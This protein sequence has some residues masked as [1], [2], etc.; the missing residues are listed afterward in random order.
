MKLQELTCTRFGHPASP[1]EITSP[2]NLL[3][4]PGS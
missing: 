1:S 3:M 4:I 2:A